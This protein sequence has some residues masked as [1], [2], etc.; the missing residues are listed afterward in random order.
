M[1]SSRFLGPI[2]SVYDLKR[3]YMTEAGVLTVLKGI[4]FTMQAGELAFIIGRSG[5]GKSTLLHL[6]GGLD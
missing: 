1:S 5:S 3:S 6:M 4:H 2:L